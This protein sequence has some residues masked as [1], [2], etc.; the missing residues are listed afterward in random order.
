[1]N[2]KVPNLSSTKDAALLEQEGKLVCILQPAIRRRIQ[3]IMD[4]SK[5][6]G[7]PLITQSGDQLYLSLTDIGN[8]AQQ[9]Q[10]YHLIQRFQAGLTADLSALPAPHRQL[11]APQQRPLRSLRGVTIC[12][13]LGVAFGILAMAV[14][15]LAIAAAELVLKTTLDE[16]S[17]LQITAVS[18]VIFTALGW[19]SSFL[20]LARY[21]KQ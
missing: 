2:I 4:A 5:G 11:L 10:A 18:F 20:L 12:I 13:I 3:H 17:G 16:F 1:M 9:A 6:K 15:I 19:A 21:A 7:H 14:S 8:E